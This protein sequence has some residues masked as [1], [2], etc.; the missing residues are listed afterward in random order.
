MRRGQGKNPM[1]LVVNNVHMIADNQE[2]QDLLEMLQQRAEKWA[3]NDLVVTGKLLFRSNPMSNTMSM[4][5][6]KCESDE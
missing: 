1:V 5:T 4:L 6:G 3:A 2:G